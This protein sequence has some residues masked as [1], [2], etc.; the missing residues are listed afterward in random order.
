[1]FFVQTSYVLLHSIAN[2]CLTTNRLSSQVRHTIGMVSYETDS[3]FSCCRY[4]GST[5]DYQGG[6]YCKSASGSCNTAKIAR[7]WTTPTPTPTPS[8]SRGRP[9]DRLEWWAIL[10]ICIIVSTILVAIFVFERRRRNKL[11]EALASARKHNRVR[12]PVVNTSTARDPPPNALPS[13]PVYRPR[14]DDADAILPPPVTAMAPPPKYSEAVG[15]DVEKTALEME[16]R[17]RD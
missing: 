16:Y 17:N 15:S 13:P 14:A 2:K 8:S 6:Y 12:L 5:I 4:Y 7:S 11:K 3:D 9:N 10:V 1:M